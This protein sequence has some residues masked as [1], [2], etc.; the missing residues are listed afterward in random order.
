L[1]WESKVRTSI[2]SMAGAMLAML[3][4]S[5][6]IVYAVNETQNILINEELQ[7]PGAVLPPGKYA[8]SVV[9]HFYDRAI[10]K[11]S[12]VGGSERYLVLA[13]PNTV[14]E[15]SAGGLVF[16]RQ[17]GDTK[18]ALKAWGALEFVYPN[19]QALK[20][21]EESGQTA[22]ALDPA[23]DRLPV[24]MSRDDMKAVTLWLLAPKQVTSGN[25]RM[26]VTAVKYA[27][28]SDSSAT[29]SVARPPAVPAPMQ[30]ASASVQHPGNK[31][32][33]TA[34]SNYA[35]LL[36]GAIL[37]SLGAGIRT[38]RVRRGMAL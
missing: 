21:I 28:A 37:F 15:N 14:K 18:A 36:Y 23:T 22:L 13:A 17:S 2:F 10:V 3:L 24:K 35:Y 29:T 26:G 4:V 30:V 33:K 12:R 7:I 8:L 11:I 27:S 1:D 25:R 34:S 16:F 38:L 19:A 5:S 32:P 20:I 31:L 6:Q 9:E